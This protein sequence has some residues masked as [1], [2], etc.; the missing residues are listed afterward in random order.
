MNKLYRCL[1]HCEQGTTRVAALPLAE[2]TL[3]A[4]TCQ[5]RPAGMEHPV[6]ICTRIDTMTASSGFAGQSSASVNIQRACMTAPALMVIGRGALFG[7]RIVGAYAELK[8][9]R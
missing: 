5:S 3:P 6:A 4:K 7:L 9:A 2:F 8:E 1:L